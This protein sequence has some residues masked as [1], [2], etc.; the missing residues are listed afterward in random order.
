[1]QGTQFGHEKLLGLFR[2]IRLLTLKL[3]NRVQKGF[4]LRLADF[5]TVEELFQDYV[6][7][8]TTFSGIV[9]DH[10]D[11]ECKENELTI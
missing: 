5:A 10:A 3:Q 2:A 7:L 6:D 11:D 9:V 1:M 8:L 4:D